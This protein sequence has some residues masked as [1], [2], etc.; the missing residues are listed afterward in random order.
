MT[1]NS[2]KLSSPILAFSNGIA[3]WVGLFFDSREAC[4]LLGGHFTDKISLEQGVPQ[5]DIISPH[6]FIL[7]V[8]VLLIKINH[9]KNLEGIKYGVVEGRSE[10]FADDTTIYIERDPKYL[11]SAVKYINDFAMI[12]GH[13]V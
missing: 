5:G 10:T 8:E 13:N 11:K 3:K 12:S 4:I 7:A 2:S 1:T 9:T 6:I